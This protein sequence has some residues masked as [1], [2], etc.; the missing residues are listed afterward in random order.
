MLKV[1]K[2]AFKMPKLKVFCLPYAGGSKSI[3]NEWIAEY[4]EVADIIPV[5]YSGHGSRFAE[6][7]NK[8]A[9]DMADDVYRYIVSEKPEN[10]VIYGHSM[11]SLISLLTAIRLEDTYD[12]PPKAVI[13]G[14]TRP[15]HLMFKD[16]KISH[17][18]KD[19]FMKEIFEIGQTDSEIME[20]PELYDILYD[21]FYADMVIGE[22]YEGSSDLPRIKADLVVMT[23]L[24]DD[25]APVEEMK[26]W[27]KYSDGSFEFKSFNDGH[28]FPFTCTDFHDYFA[29]LIN[30]ES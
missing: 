18:P 4:K 15:P 16:H 8:S 27:Q 19:V 20:E 21:I 2:E 17:L 24:K 5:E 30:A 29:S 10:Y 14:G 6:E 22:T 3:F 26:E 25:E 1:K 23:G 7:L 13:V 12:Y 9:D 28:F 11:G